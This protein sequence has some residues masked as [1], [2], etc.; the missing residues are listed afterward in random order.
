MLK[1]KE[2]A[3]RCLLCADGV[4]TKACKNG[5][6]PARAVRSVYFDNAEN[7]S[8]FVDSAICAECSGECEHACV[9]YDTPIRIRELVNRLP[10]KNELPQKDLSIDFMGV[11]FENPFILSSSIV[12]G[13]YDM[14]ASAFKAGWAGAAFK[15]IGFLKPKE[16]SPRFDA[17]SKESTPFVGFRN[18]EQISDRDLSLNLDDLKRLKKDF[19]TK[20]IVASIMGQNEEE[21]TRLSE[22]VTEAGADIIECN[23]SCPQMCG[24]GLGSDVGQDPDLVA[25]YTAA[26]K[27]DTSIPVLAKMTPN[28]GNMEI[29]AIAAV[30]AGADGIAAINTVKSITGLSTDCKSPRLDI[31]GKSAVSGYSGKAVKPIALRFISDMKHS[32]ELK[33]IP[34][35][36]MGGIETWHDAA[37]FM[38]LGCGNVQVTTAVMQ[39]GYRIIDDLISG[40][41]LFLSENGYEHLSDFVGTAISEFVPADDLNRSSIVY[42]SF[43]K[44]QCVGCGRCMLSCKDA[45]HQALSLDSDTLKPRLSP[46]KCVGCHL[47]ALVCPTGSIGQSKR[48]ELKAY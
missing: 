28:L 15:T 48:I 17:I 23:F 47:C 14:C 35:S 39:Y 10:L 7:A 26:V 5:F 37:E 42:P 19:P 33:N 16:V 2:E 29:P 25:R 21:W 9:H 31:S 8:A 22:L 18:L 34:I 32:P 36:G 13:S 1:I 24:K 12:A 46:K 41:S 44:K 40:L 4:C 30:K 45:G 38:A 20:I 11:H 3:A 6:D 27:K 43:D